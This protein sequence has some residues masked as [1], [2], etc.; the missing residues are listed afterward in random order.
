MRAW[1]DP[2]VLALVAAVALAAVLPC[3]G[4][5]ASALGGAADGAIALLFFLHGGRLS[6]DVIAR[7]VKHW[8]LQVVVLVA[9]FALFPLL[10]LAGRA[11]LTLLMPTGLPEPLLAGVVVLS[12]LPSTVQSSI[13]FTAIARGNIPAAI[14]CAALSNVVGVFAS[15]L[16]V[17]MLLGVGGAS[18]SLGALWKIVGLL[19]APFIVGHLSRP[20]IRGWLERNKGRLGWLDRG[21]I[22]LIVY[23]AFSEGVVGGIWRQ[24]P[25]L[26]ITALVVV[27][28]VLLAAVIATL[29]A[30][31]RRLRFTKEDEIAIVFCGSKKSLAS[32]L[33]MAKLLFVGPSVGLTV[34]PLMLFHQL[35]LMVCAALARRYARRAD[36]A[37]SSR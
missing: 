33:P 29:T 12:V 31:S 36:G 5:L 11:L 17:A 30:V 2:Y 13:A 10:G 3:R 25:P 20:V 18:G 4:S 14:C 28:G 24:V 19:L 9:T 27:A 35:Q 8:R 15:P 7:G 23:I 26:A 21:A 34:L 32:G 37:T 6:R 22:L 16:L 1:L